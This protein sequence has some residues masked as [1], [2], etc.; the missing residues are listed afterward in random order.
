MANT[1][2]GL[3]EIDEVDI[4]WAFS[5]L[6]LLYGVYQCNDLISASSSLPQSRLFLPQLFVNSCLESSKKDSKENFAGD[7][8]ECDSPPVVTDLTVA[9]LSE[10]YHDSF[11]PVT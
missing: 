9:F 2:K 10:L 7:G 6:S 8:Q 1:V 4:L 3:F 11:S 5:F